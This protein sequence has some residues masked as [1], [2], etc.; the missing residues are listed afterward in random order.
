MCQKSLICFRKYF[1]NSLCDYKKKKKYG[2]RN[3]V[4]ISIAVKKMHISYNILICK[5]LDYMELFKFN[6][7]INKLYK[8]CQKH[9]IYF[10]ILPIL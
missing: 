2:F 10:K 4:Y 7:H 8:F 5:N 3:Q 9:F 1:P 6:V